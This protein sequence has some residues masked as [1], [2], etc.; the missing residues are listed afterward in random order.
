[1]QAPP[2]PPE[3]FPV[4][5]AAALPQATWRGLADTGLSLVAPP[6]GGCF[7]PVFFLG[8]SRPCGQIPGAAGVMVPAAF[9]GAGRARWL[10]DGGLGWESCSPTPRHHGP[11][12]LTSGQASSS[13][14]AGPCG[15]LF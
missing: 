6:P 10:S 12:L 1:M 14:G 11:L 4:E 5:S 15:P 2:S 3:A 8:R 13:M 7:C 9:Q